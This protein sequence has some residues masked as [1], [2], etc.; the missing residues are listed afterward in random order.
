MWERLEMEELTEVGWVQSGIPRHTGW[1]ERNRRGCCRCAT[2]LEK[3]GAFVLLWIYYI[4]R[5]A[6][7]R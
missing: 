1:S 6:G 2:P 7:R 4:V 5:F 3:E